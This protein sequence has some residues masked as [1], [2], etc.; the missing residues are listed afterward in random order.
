LLEERADAGEIVVAEADG[1]EGA[2]A[3]AA[4]E[5]ADDDLL[6]VRRGEGRDAQVDDGAAHRH[7]G[8]TV[9]R[10][11][12][13]GDVEPGEN[14]HARGQ[15]RRERACEKLR[16]AQHAVD[17]MAHRDS[18]LFRLDVDVA[19]AGLDSVGEQLIDERNGGGDVVERTLARSESKPRCWTST[20]A[21]RCSGARQSAYHRASCA[22]SRAAVPRPNALRSAGGE[23]DGTFGVEVERVAR[24]NDE[25]T[26]LLAQRQDGIAPRPALAEQRDGGWIDVREIGA[27]DGGGHASTIPIF[28][29]A[30]ASESCASVQISN[31]R[32]TGA[33]T[34][35]PQPE[36]MTLG[37]WMERDYARERRGSYRRASRRASWRSCT[38]DSSSSADVAPMRAMNMSHCVSQASPWVPRNASAA[39]PTEDRGEPLDQLVGGAECETHAHDEEAEPLAARQGRAAEQHLAREHRRDETLR[40]VAD[41]VVVVSRQ[42]ERILRPEAE[43]HLRVRVVPAQHQDERVHEQQAVHEWREREASR[44][45]HEDRRDDQDRRDLEQP[46]AGSN[47]P[48]RDSASSTMTATSR[49]AG[50]RRVMALRR[51]HRRRRHGRLRA[52]RGSSRNRA[53]DRR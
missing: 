28:G 25:H 21:R 12:A 48:M 37:S 2:E 50:S 6:A 42:T 46:G 44:G 24:R 52:A 45:E 36:R 17:A 31:G 16:L 14:L 13:V 4:V 49:M 5:N 20:A 38:R 51:R 26:I 8:T 23:G 3:G 33:R 11:H 10:P 41:A 1:V 29:F 39:E 22:G 19:R 30:P 27:L 53:T 18:L 15:R 32:I 47:A 35:A 9:L 7:A 43:R 40:E 34:P